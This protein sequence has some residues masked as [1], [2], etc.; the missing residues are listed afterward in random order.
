MT[1]SGGTTHA[2]TPPSFH[3]DLR[4][5]RFLPQTVVGRRSLHLV[6]L[7]MRLRRGARDVEVVEVAGGV[8]AR[9]HRPPAGPRP[10]VPAV[11]YLHGGGYVV[12][13]AA[14]GDPFCARLA[15]H[16]GVVVAAVNYRLAPEHP[17]PAALEDAY[18]ALRWLAEQPEVDAG[19][20][21]LVGESAG[22]GLAA[23][24]A[25]L[26]RDRGEITPV[27]QVLSYPMLDD[28][29]TDAGVD[30]RV[31]RLWNQPSNRFGWDAYL[32]DLA[33]QVVPATAAPARA[34]ELSGLPPTWIG[35]GTH[36][37]FYAENAAWVQRLDAAGVPSELFVVDG[38]Y[39]GFDRAEPD[40]EVSR[41]FLRARL[42]ALRTALDDRT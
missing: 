27:V 4:R 7:G 8:N 9:I 14:M 18:A 25:L 40:A 39:H 35:V 3:P 26:A 28:Q 17:Y 41:V 34:G 2:D 22:G 29:T 30:P 36:D 42:T 33:G 19:R 21:A 11:V 12:G 10:A 5:A 20:I 1:A 15:R 23:A 32:G 13:T 31:L 24:V 16:L 38:A 37:L 6:R